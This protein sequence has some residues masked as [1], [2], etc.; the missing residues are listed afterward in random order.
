[1]SVWS[2]VILMMIGAFIHDAYADCGLCYTCLDK[3][4]GGYCDDPFDS[5]EHKCSVGPCNMGIARCVFQKLTMKLEGKCINL[6]FSS[7]DELMQS[8]GV[9]R[10]SVCLCVCRSVR[11]SVCKL[12]SANRFYYAKNRSPATELPQD[13]LQVDAH[14]GCAQGQGQRS[15]DTGTCAEHEN[16]F[17][18]EADGRTATNLALDGLQVSLHLG[19]AQGQGQGQRSRD[20]GT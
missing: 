17:F 10:L 12:F 7:F 14:P 4:P 15:R 13:G 6:F 2:V 18:S 3:K 19:S 1:M 8:R 11:P 5:D 20:T 16:R 9:R